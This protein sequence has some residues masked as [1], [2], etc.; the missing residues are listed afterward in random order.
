MNH[1]ETSIIINALIMS[2]AKQSYP[3]L[4]LGRRIISGLV[5]EDKLKQL[6]AEISSEYAKPLTRG[7]SDYVSGS[8]VQTAKPTQEESR[9]NLE[10]ADRHLHVTY[11]RKDEGFESDG[12]ST[13][14]SSHSMEIPS[15]TNDKSQTSEVTNINVDRLLNQPAVTNASGPEVKIVNDHVFRQ[16]PDNKISFGTQSVSKSQASPTNSLELEMSSAASSGS[17]YDENLAFKSSGPHSIM[18]KSKL[19]T[20][21][22]PVPIPD[23]GK[24]R[25][26][27]INY[28]DPNSSSEVT[29][30]SATSKS[31]SPTADLQKYKFDH[32]ETF[33]VKDVMV[34]HIDK[35]IGSQLAWV[36]RS[37][38]RNIL[39]LVFKC[40]GGEGDVNQIT[41]QFNEM[42]RRSKF[43]FARRRKTTEN[44]LNPNNN[45]KG[46]NAVS[47]SV[48]VLLGRNKKSIPDPL[49]VPDGETQRPKNSLNPGLL[50]QSN[51]SNGHYKLG[52]PSDARNIELRNGHEHHPSLMTLTHD[53]IGL[54]HYSHQQTRQR[55]SDD[56]KRHQEGHKLWNLVQHT[57]R[58]GI[59][60]I[61][62]ESKS[63][64]SGLDSPAEKDNDMSGNNHL[65]K[66]RESGKI[67]SS[68]P[69]IRDVTDASTPKQ[70]HTTNNP[71]K[72]EQ[73]QSYFWNSKGNV[74]SDGLN[75]QSPRKSHFAVE[76]ESLLTKELH[77]RKSKDGS[78]ESK[79]PKNGSSQN[80]LL[81]EKTITKIPRP[82]IPTTSEP[83]SLRQ[84]APALLLRKLDMITE[85]SGNRSASND[86][87]QNDNNLWTKP[88]VKLTSSTQIDRPSTQ[89]NT[90]NQDKIFYPSKLANKSPL[91]KAKKYLEKRPTTSEKL[92]VNGTNPIAEKSNKA[93]KWPND[94]LTHE[95]AKKDRLNKL[96]TDLLQ[97][98]NT[99]F[100]KDNI[101]KK[102]KGSPQKTPKSRQKKFEKGAD[103]AKE[104]NEPSTGFV[105]ANSDPSSEKVVS[106][107]TAALPL[108][109]FS[110]HFSLSVNTKSP[111]NEEGNNKSDGDK[112]HK[113]DDNQLQTSTSTQNQILV[114]TKTGKEPSRKY[115]P[116]E[117]TIPHPGGVVFTTPA[118]APSQI[119]INPALFSNG[120]RYIHVTPMLPTVQFT[121]QQMSAQPHSL[122]MAFPLP[123]SSNPQ[124]GWTPYTNNHEF[125]NNETTKNYNAMI[126]AQAMQ[127]RNHQAQLQA[128][129][130]AAD[131]HAATISNTTPIQ[132]A[133]RVSRGR[134]RE[135]VDNRATKSEIGISSMEQQ[136]RRAQSK[137]PARQR[138]FN[139]NGSGRRH[140]DLEEYERERGRSSGE[141]EP[142]S[143]LSGLQIGKR[144]RV[145]GDAM[146]QAMNG[147]RRPGD[148][149]STSNQMNAAT[150]LGTPHLQLKSNLKKNSNA[151]LP[152]NIINATSS[153]TTQ[154]MSL[155]SSPGQSSP[156]ESDISFENCAKP[157]LDDSALSSSTRDEVDGGM[158]RSHTS[159]NAFSYTGA[160]PK[161]EY[162]QNHNINAC[163]SSNNR[164]DKKVH[165]NK[166][167]TVQMM[168]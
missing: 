63:L 72:N 168:E 122:P 15:H 68:G 88:K 75:S 164:E 31:N 1:D 145:L 162:P 30:S 129:Q 51:L 130:H 43:E 91:P 166:F 85:K 79:P 131:H 64:P 42:R 61:E 52:I 155:H 8:R 92:S 76:L 143:L 24:Q 22:H 37:N 73:S 146:R 96:K 102:E 161:P 101:S 55:G 33:S 139:A 4:F 150:P 9:C 114:P 59:T 140:V 142:Q 165:F 137:S 103:N 49:M 19:D 21:N 2:E 123:L 107:K 156:N 54:R 32:K 99:F 70:L 25:V 133:S 128:A 16:H 119:P 44:I 65:A 152:E 100:N 124:M 160:G 7:E 97:Q 77:T 98:S 29:S 135:R 50:Y 27:D 108:P 13:K 110:D 39:I 95:S 5:S 159:G 83:L 116:K 82:K 58:N 18:V 84:R 113:K 36:I 109:S 60:H 11:I 90:T 94:E 40:V 148:K 34:C 138:G 134:S 87:D 144:F 112:E 57:D 121:A 111:A 167:A 126:Q 3:A 157:I 104:C 74:R 81:M 48:E 78:F 120:N 26:K 158:N 14:S 17:D 93:P 136:R 118:G 147:G 41:T 71:H 117:S 20:N 56:D 66:T 151:L 115:Y 149:L 154:S 35:N 38:R 45:T 47:K 163:N 12:E 141:A 62:I 105:F 89:S 53:N 80:G 69:N 153:T 106:S 23:N 86:G 10:V 28:V 6:V 46:K 125:R 132:N 127:W 67:P